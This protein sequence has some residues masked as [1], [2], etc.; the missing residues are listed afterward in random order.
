MDSLL[1]SQN[2]SQSKRKSPCNHSERVSPA[3]PAEDFPRSKLQP[4][5]TA[6]DQRGSTL[7]GITPVVSLRKNEVSAEDLQLSARSDKQMAGQSQNLN[8]QRPQAQIQSQ[9]DLK[10]KLSEDLRDIESNKL[11][12]SG[13]KQGSNE[14]NDDAEQSVQHGWDRARRSQLDKKK[15]KK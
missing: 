15:M 4:Y 1:K 10:C 9:D 7:A 2:Q 12:A 8:E 3:K 14:T 13:E 11:N 5:G 6:V